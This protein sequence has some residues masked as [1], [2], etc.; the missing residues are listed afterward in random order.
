VVAHLELLA[1]RR[2]VGGRCRHEANGPSLG[3]FENSNATALQDDG[4]GLD[5][6]PVTRRIDPRFR[7]PVATVE[8]LVPTRSSTA[9]LPAKREY[10]VTRPRRRRGVSA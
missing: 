8:R 6:R 1:I 7:H 2:M 9:D 10:A 4:A 3:G 5:T